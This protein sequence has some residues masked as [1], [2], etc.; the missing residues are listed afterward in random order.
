MD[1]TLELIVVPVTDVDRAKAFYMDKTGFH[2]DVD[3]SAGEDFRIVQLTPPGS[4][5]SICLMRV[6]ERAGMVKGLHLIVAD[7]EAAHAELA[8]R[9]LEVSELFH[10]GPGGQAGG[11]HPE[12][13]NYGSFMSFNDPDDNQWLVQEVDRSKSLPAA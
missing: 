1:Y 8:A 5:C 2:L 9:G 12:R 3:H 6:P 13:A 7:I 11:P 4:A 10:F